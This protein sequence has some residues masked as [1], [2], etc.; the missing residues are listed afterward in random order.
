VAVVIVIPLGAVKSMPMV[1]LCK[2]LHCH[3]LAIAEV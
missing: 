1:I 3:T 2:G